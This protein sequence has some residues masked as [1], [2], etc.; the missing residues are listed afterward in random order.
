MT[1]LRDTLVVVAIL[2]VIVACAVGLR[3][4][5]LELAKSI[6][7]LNVTMERKR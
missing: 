2:C 6:D 1:W 7:K 4:A 3:Q 5:V